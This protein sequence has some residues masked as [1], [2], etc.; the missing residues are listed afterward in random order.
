[1]RQKKLFKEL[2][3][4]DID[5]V[6]REK[7]NNIKKNNILKI[8]ENINA[9]FTCTYLHY[10]KLFKETKFEKSISDRIKLRKERLYIINKNKENISNELFE[11]YFNYSNPDTMIKILKNVND[12]INKNMV[13]SI[14]KNLN[15]MKKNH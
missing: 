15:K 9:I 2:I 1:M 4:R 7:S 8:L 13:E 12:E 11:E 3:Q 6:E 14:N 10:R 5:P